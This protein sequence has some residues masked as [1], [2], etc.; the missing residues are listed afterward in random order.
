MEKQR[1]EDARRAYWQSLRDTF[2]NK[3]DE[4][5][6]ATLQQSFALRSK[7]PVEKADD[8]AYEAG[9]WLGNVEVFPLV[10]LTVLFCCLTITVCKTF[11]KDP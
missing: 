11:F 5:L 10:V 3:T 6:A 4:E 8:T 1:A 9:R 2:K 7:P